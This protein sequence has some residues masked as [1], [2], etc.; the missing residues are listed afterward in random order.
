L[1]GEGK[2]VDAAAAWQTA[3]G[4]LGAAAPPLNA[5]FLVQAGYALR[6]AQR[7]EGSEDAFQQAIRIASPCGW[8]L[9][10]QVSV[11]I[12]QSLRQTEFREPLGYYQQALAARPDSRDLMTA[13]ILDR[14]GNETLNLGRHSEAEQ[15]LRRALAIQQ[16]LAPE[17]LASAHSLFLLGVI[18]INRDDLAE[19]GANFNRALGI[20]ESKG[21]IAGSLTSLSYL[22]AVARRRGELANAEAYA[23][24]AVSL[25]ERKEPMSLFLAMVLDNL[26]SVLRSRGDFRSS[27][28]Y[29]RRAM[30]IKSKLAPNG[31]H[32]AA[33]LKMLALLA[34]ERGDWPQAQAYARRALRM[35]QK[36]DPGGQRAVDSIRFLGHLAYTQGNFDKAQEY[37]LQALK[38]SPGASTSEILAE[39]GDVAQARGNYE[40]AEMRYRDC[41]DMETKLNPGSVTHVETLAAL[42][43]R[44]RLRNEVKEAGLKYEEAL[45]R[46]EDVANRWGGNDEIRA[47]FRATHQN[48]YREYADLLISQGR[49]ESG[50]EVL[51]RSRARA[52]L[53]TLL[54][55]HVDVHEGADP[56]L[57]EKARSLSSSIRAKQESRAR[58][59]A[60]G[61]TDE[62]LRALEKEIGDR[63]AEYKALDDRI[64][65]AYP[66]YATL[67]RPQLL[68]AKQ[69]Q[70]QLLDAD[71]LLLEFS[72]GEERSFVFA[73][74]PDSLQAFELPKRAE[75]EKLARR[76]Y[77]LLTV[78]NRVILA[79]APAQ[80][81]DRWKRAERDF[82]EA[83]SALSRM[84]LGPI[85]SQL[86]NKRLLLVTDGALAYV[87]FSLLPEPA[88]STPVPLVTNH[89]IVNLPSASVLAVLRQQELNRPTAAKAVAVLAD[90]VFD[91]HDERL[92]KTRMH[93]P[94]SG[95]GSDRDDAEADSFQAPPKPSGLLT[96]SATDVGL[97]RRGGAL[98][99]RLRFSRQEADAIMG[100]TP[101]GMGMKAVDF[102][103]NRSHAV[104]P[105][106]REYRIVHFATHGLL[107]SAHPELSGLVLS[108]VDKNGKP[109]DGFLDLQDIYNLNLSADLVVLSACETG[110]GKEINGE[111]L[112]GLTRGFMHAGASRVVASL[113]SVSDA[114]TARLMA[115]FYKA[116]EKEGLRP[117]AALR[118]AQIHIRSQKRWS[119]PYYW[120]A[121]QI[122]GEWK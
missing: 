78:R 5:W 106:L 9:T 13:W 43:N 71:T 76:V 60:E 58:L 23:R 104:S 11:A 77:A 49:P 34:Q 111:G 84:I 55:A 14:I 26:S 19:A 79:E 53:E 22:G 88:V 91:Q 16:E 108:L 51:E 93:A 82:I 66:G 27:E 98:L 33:S 35:T 69:I 24:R 122:Q 32:M 7:K 59:L 80:R 21:A 90:P 102:A 8:E 113:W 117:A 36:I 61:H 3:S 92:S 65:S 101:S 38:I 85:A 47:D 73:V 42:A 67:T 70:G 12:A 118:Q 64:R 50:F 29:C 97:G 83:S 48:Y 10:R 39:L 96:R 110:L 15:Q 62:Q 28:E 103:A 105:E 6:I 44:L 86:A 99:P 37:L 115:E 89:E 17:G 46:L 25:L 72:L 112:I 56:A 107:D 114:A 54:A 52:L 68:T 109:Q 81:E 87:P 1:A 121:F 119:S 31:T 20:Q 40:E 94:A 95:R 100:V 18:A 4:R 116:M 75:I 2:E 45:E 30:A 57:I 74:S 120:A 41:L 63:T